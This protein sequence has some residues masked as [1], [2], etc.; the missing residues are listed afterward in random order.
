MVGLVAPEMDKFRRLARILA[1]LA[2]AKKAGFSPLSITQMHSFA[3]LVNV[4]SPVWSMPPM[5]A[6]VLKV[7]K[8]PYYP[9]LQDDIDE[10]IGR[11]VVMISDIEYI[12]D[13]ERSGLRLDGNIELNAEF[14][15]RIFEVML[16]FAEERNF[17]VFIDELALA[18]ATLSPAEFDLSAGEDA[19]Y[20]DVNI[21]Y[22][23]VVDFA[24]YKDRNYSAKAAMFLGRL[25]RS[26][27]ATTAGEKL[28]LYVRH[29][30]DRLQDAR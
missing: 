20:G 3:F 18:L 23:D 24:E 10:L 19:T 22:D 17:Q 12:V 27:A 8:G 21:A 6:R 5:D 9:G 7:R 26:G 1:L 14:A 16:S 25:A 13:D 2:G 29:M 11:S 28:H 4:L 30:R 15:P